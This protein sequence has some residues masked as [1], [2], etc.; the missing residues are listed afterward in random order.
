MTIRAFRPILDPN[1]RVLAQFS[2]SG[3]LLPASWIAFAV[4]DGNYSDLIRIDPI[5]DAIRKLPH[6]DAP[7]TWVDFGRSLRKAPYVIECH[8]HAEEETF[9]NSLPLLLLVILRFGKVLFRLRGND[10]RQ[11]HGRARSR[12]L[13][14]SQVEPALGLA[15]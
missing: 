6:H 7:D 2:R 15:S 3:P 5:E 8:L 9:P 1:R 4:I 10:E 11:I 12:A 14:T 13:T